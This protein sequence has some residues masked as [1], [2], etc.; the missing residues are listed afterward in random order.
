MCKM[1]NKSSDN[2]TN[3][4]TRKCRMQWIRE[5]NIKGQ[6]KRVLRGDFEILLHM[7][8]DYEG[9]TQEIGD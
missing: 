4:C 6:K 2:G 8:F 3:F 7:V 9:N 5:H 1:C